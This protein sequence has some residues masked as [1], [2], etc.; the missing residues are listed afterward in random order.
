ELLAVAAAAEASSEHPLAKAMV[1]AA[2]EHGATPPD[3]ASFEAV[4]G[5]GVVAKIGAGEGLVGN[6]RFL[7]DRNI[8][9]TRLRKDIETPEAVGRT[10]I[11]V[12]RDG[13]ALGVVALGDTLRPDAVKAVAALRNA[14]LKAILVTG[15]N[16][17]A[18]RWVAREVGI[19]EVHA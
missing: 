19:E 14:G 16:E 4:P 15:D 11:G 12:A 7:V 10:V 3:V 1:K 17:R 2:F 18:A 8:D 9:L 5:Q 13:R 6:P